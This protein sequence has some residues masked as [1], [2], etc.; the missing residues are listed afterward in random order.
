MACLGSI[1]GPRKSLILQQLGHPYFGITPSQLGADIGHHYAEQ[2]GEVQPV[3]RDEEG[4]PCIL[5]SK[6]RG[7]DRK[8]L[9]RGA[10]PAA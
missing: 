2:R 7:P 1:K 4:R 10:W 9:R 8:I 3:S 6:K 5:L